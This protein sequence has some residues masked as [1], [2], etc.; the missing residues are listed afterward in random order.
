MVGNLHEFESKQLQSVAKGELDL[1]KLADADRDLARSSSER[2]GTHAQVQVLT[3]SNVDRLGHP[4][5]VE[6]R[7]NG[8]RVFHHEGDELADDRR[9]LHRDDLS[10]QRLHQLRL[11]AGRER[12][13]R[14]GQHEFRNLEGV[15][16]LGA[17][18][19]DLFESR[20]EQAFHGL[21]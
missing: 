15:A 4:Q 5:G 18:L 3:V 11:A 6:C 1:G 17:P 21:L 13:Q 16:H 7:R 8:A 2:V 12:R 10:G 9:R 14:R 20:I 19:G